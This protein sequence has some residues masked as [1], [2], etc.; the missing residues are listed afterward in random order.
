[1]KVSELRDAFEAL[2]DDR[3]NNFILIIWLNEAQE[4]ISLYYSPVESV[5]LYA[6]AMVYK[7]LPEDL[8][9]VIEVKD[10]NEN[11]CRNFEITEYGHIRFADTGTYTIY[12]NRKPKDMPLGEDDA[13]P[14]LPELLHKPLYVFAAS[15]FF[16]RESIG[17]PE[18]SQFAQKLMEQYRQMVTARANKLRARRSKKLSMVAE[19]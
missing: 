1:M 17:D 13:K 6:E 14:D 8:L 2:V 10:E 5:E 7:E 11:V 19:E 18:E 12:Y 4:D 16:D 9:R 15:R 3:V